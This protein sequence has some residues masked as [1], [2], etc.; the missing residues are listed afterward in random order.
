M[1]FPGQ[2]GR[3]YCCAWCL[4]EQ[5][6][7]ST[8]VYS[9]NARCM[10]QYAIAHLCWRCNWHRACRR[11]PEADLK[12]VLVRHLRCGDRRLNLSPSKAEDA[13]RNAR[14]ADIMSAGA[15]VLSSCTFMGHAHPGLTTSEI[16]S[17]SEKQPSNDN[18]IPA[19]TL[20]LTY[21]RC[22]L[23]SDTHDIPLH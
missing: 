1:H 18:R 19:S 22:E 10:V 20:T 14:H 16:L 13:G 21:R 15:T 7:A 5:L 11:Q 12:S 4:A 17:L 9:Q 8:A 3:S 6:S 2:D 23:V